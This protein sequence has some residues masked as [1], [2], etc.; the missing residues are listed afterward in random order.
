V[1]CESHEGVSPISDDF[2]L[3]N[4]LPW[5]RPLINHEINTRLN[6]YTNMSTISQNL[7]KI[8]LVVSEISLLQAIVKKDDDD[9]RS[10]RSIT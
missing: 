1:E 5:Q 4:W 10:N 8:G 6:I 9:E 3:K 2:A 7:V